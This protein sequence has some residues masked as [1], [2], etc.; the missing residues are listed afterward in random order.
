MMLYNIKNDMRISMENEVCMIEFVCC[1]GEVNFV[2]VVWFLKL[3]LMLEY[4]VGDV[5]FVEYMMCFGVVLGID[6]MFFFQYIFVFK[7]GDG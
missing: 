5:V 1:I 4:I 2:E 6:L 7:D 3:K